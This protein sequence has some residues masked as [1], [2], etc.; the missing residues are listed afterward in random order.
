MAKKE[1]LS[2]TLARIRAELDRLP[3]YELERLIDSGE[4]D[5]EPQR[6]AKRILRDRYS[7]P[8]R[9][10]A[11]RLYNVAAWTLAFAFGA[12]VVALLTFWL[13]AISD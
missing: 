10:L 5:P 6:D 11:R 3:T 2:E 12:F 4:L 13:M 9:K 1:G 7:E 8:D